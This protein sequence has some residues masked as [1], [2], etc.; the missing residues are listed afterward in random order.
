MPPKSQQILPGLVCR[1][2]WLALQ[3]SNSMWWSCA[4]AAMMA[5]C[6]Q[7]KC[8]YTH[9]CRDCGGPHPLVSCPSAF[10]ATPSHSRSST[11][12]GPTPLLKLSQRWPTFGNCKR[13]PSNA[14][15]DILNYS[16][17]LMKTETFHAST[18]GPTLCIPLHCQIQI[19]FKLKKD[20]VF[21]SCYFHDVGKLSFQDAQGHV[22][23]VSSAH[24]K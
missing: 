20:L 23:W 22:I 2:S 14:N 13:C 21:A 11:N 24:K 8:R 7:A 1:D 9:A 17:M 19:S 18:Y 4:N 5:K 6:R 15:L 10:N 3:A 12:V 16:W